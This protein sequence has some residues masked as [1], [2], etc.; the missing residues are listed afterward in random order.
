MNT[1]L[2]LSD[3]SLMNIATTDLNLLKVFEALY[4]EGSASRAA[5]LLG[6]TQSA[7]SA[8]LSR[9][10]GVYGDQLFVR[11]GRGLTPT[12][13]ANQLKPV[14]SEALNKCR[15][16]LSM[17]MPAPASF[18]GR[19]VTIGLSDDFEIAI[20]QRL[21]AAIARRA[22]Q[23]RVIFRQSHSQIISDAL[24]ERSIDLGITAGGLSSRTLS[25]ALLGEGGYSC[26]ADPEHTRLSPHTFDMAQFVEH[27][28]VLISSGGFIGIVDEALAP[29][30]LQRKVLASTTHF[31]ALPYLLKGT[32]AIATAPDHAAQAIARIGGLQVLPCPLPLRRY[33]IELGWRTRELN[34]AAVLEA[35]AA[36][37]E[38]FS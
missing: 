11:N 31:A 30:G 22:P 33:S 19:S 15:Q 28:Q 32:R 6:V 35:K 13:L 37:E 29:L 5:I 7:V 14:V 26:L 16:S 21:M 12:L 8:A 27:D 20:G 4:E 18:Q 36:I 25:R 23:L 3:M 17:A 1:T 24:L 10:R 38:C 2:L 34:E 9:L